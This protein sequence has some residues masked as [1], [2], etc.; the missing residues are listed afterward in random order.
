MLVPIIVI[1][2]ALVVAGILIARNN[3]KSVERV[4]GWFQSLKKKK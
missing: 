3:P 4:V 1:G 2:L